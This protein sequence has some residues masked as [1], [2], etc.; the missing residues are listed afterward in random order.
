M[1]TQYDHFE[2]QF[3]WPFIFS[4][5]TLWFVTGFYVGALYE[6]DKRKLGTRHWRWYMI[7]IFFPHIRIIHC[8]MWLLRLFCRLP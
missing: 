2:V 8:F 3:L 6:W 5:F 4:V 1:L 7:L